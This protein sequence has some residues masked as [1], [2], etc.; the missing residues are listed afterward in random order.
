VMLLGELEPTFLKILDD[1]RC[2]RWGVE[3]ADADGVMF[4]CPACFQ[5][6]GGSVGT[7]SIICWQ[8]HVDPKRDPKP[9]RWPFTGTSIEDLTLSPSISLPGDGCGAHFF[10]EN[11]EIR[12]V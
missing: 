5:K 12:L 4:L 2:Q 10:I 6:N 11:G 7:H 8:P 3:L 1:R 9:G